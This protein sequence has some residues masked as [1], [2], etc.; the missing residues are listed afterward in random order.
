MAHVGQELLLVGERG[1][2][3]VEHRV[4]VRPAARSRR[5]PGPGS[6]AR[7][8]SP[9]S[10]GGPRQRLERGHRAAG[11]EPDEQRGQQ[12]HHDRDAHRDR[13]ALRPARGWST[14]AAR[15]PSEPCRAPAVTGTAISAPARAGCRGRRS[16]ARRG[17]PSR[18]APTRG[19]RFGSALAARV[20]VVDERDQRPSRWRSRGVQEG[21]EERGEMASEGPSVAGPTPDARGSSRSRHVAGERLVHLVVDAR[22]QDLPQHD[23]RRG[24]REDQQDE[25]GDEDPGPH[26]R[27]GPGPGLAWRPPPVTRRFLAVIR[28][29]IA[30]M[31]R[32][33]SRLAA[34]PEARRGQR[35]RDDVCLVAHQGSLEESFVSSALT[36]SAYRSSGRIGTPRGRAR[37]PCCRVGR[38][39]RG[40]RWSCRDCR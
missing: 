12:Q 6:A 30:G 24:C 14:G 26:A 32:H 16:G 19:S 10:T 15:P 1:L 33:R 25:E 34:P 38:G 7:G 39:C 37:R 5:R 27:R 31:R 13:T 17:A 28:G 36:V 21:V 23:E 18:S 22:E 20:A 3:A 29:A 9:R 40:F 4:Q 8:P 11:G 2:E 35:A